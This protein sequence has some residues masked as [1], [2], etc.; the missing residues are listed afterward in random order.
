MLVGRTAIVA[1]AIGGAAVLG[2]ATSIISGNKAANAQEDA[3]NKSVAEQQREYDQAR[4]DY[5]PWRNTGTGALSKL[6]SLY[7]INSDGTTGAPSQSAINDFQNTPG[8]QFQLQQGTQAAEHSAA[9]RGLLGSGAAM[10]SIASYAGGLADSTYNQYVGQLNT[11]AGFGQSATNATTAA[12]QNA[13]NNISSAYTN[14]GNARAS[15]YANTGSAINGTLQN[16]ASVY[17]YGQ[18]GGFGG[19]G[20]AGVGSSTYHPYGGNL[21]AIY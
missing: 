1:V 19:A 6:G 10:K 14:A 9:A 21:G 8:Y 2:G 3:A 5:A 18:G 4:S 16:L 13:A 11:L 7:G 15:S 17:A 20:V 12:G